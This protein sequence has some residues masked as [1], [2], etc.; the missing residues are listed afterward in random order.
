MLMLTSFNYWTQKAKKLD[1]TAYAVKRKH[2]SPLHA[3]IAIVFEEFP[4]HVSLWYKEIKI[5]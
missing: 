3:Y 1:T 5:W 2:N 4:M